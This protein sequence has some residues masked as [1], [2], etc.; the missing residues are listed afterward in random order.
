MPTVH[1]PGVSEPRPRIHHPYAYNASTSIPFG[2]VVDE[3]YDEGLPAVPAKDDLGKRR[4]S[5]VM[6]R[7]AGTG[8]R[9]GAHEY[10]GPRMGSS[11]T[12][13]VGGPDLGMFG[14]EHRSPR[15]AAVNYLLASEFCTGADMIQTSR[16]GGS[17]IKTPIRPVPTYEAPMEPLPP[18]PKAKTANSTHGR[19]PVPVAEPDHPNIHRVHHDYP[20]SHH[21]AAQKQAAAVENARAEALAR[22]EAKRGEVQDTIPTGPKGPRQTYDTVTSGPSFGHID[23]YGGHPISARQS[24][25]LPGSQPMVREPAGMGNSFFRIPFGV[26]GGAVL[27]RPMMVMRTG[28]G[29]GMGV[30][31]GSVGL[32]SGA[33]GGGG[34]RLEEVKEISEGSRRRDDKSAFV[35]TVEDVS[36]TPRLIP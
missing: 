7:G 31:I 18:I 35:E 27:P 3:Q 1:D 5:E 6:S 34:A 12:E 33:G 30:G 8:L 36:P 32:G 28:T 22:L 13:G 2:A 26:P 24:H 17:P 20:F 11:K 10:G 29:V 23:H 4:E 19:K 15:K 25:Q 14:Q 9:S 16:G 21:E